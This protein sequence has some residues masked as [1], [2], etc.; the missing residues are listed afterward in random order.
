ML[1]LLLTVDFDQQLGQFPQR[2]QRYHLTVHVGARA[3]IRAD[4]PPHHE[5]AV[6]IDRLLFEPGAGS[7]RQSR[8]ARADFGTLGTLARDIAGPAPAGDQQQRVHDDGFT[9][10]GLAGERGQAAA[11][12]EL[13]LIDENQIPQLKMRQ[14]GLDVGASVVARRGPSAAW[15]AAADSSHSPAGAAA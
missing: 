7:L 1:E 5:L 9:R 8:K 13:G 2:L 14:H 15:S 11:E 4:H 12:F 3:A 6:A 10:A